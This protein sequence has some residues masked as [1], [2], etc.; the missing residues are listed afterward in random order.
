MADAGRLIFGSP[1][2][3]AYMEPSKQ[4][5]EAIVHFI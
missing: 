5:L 4:G 3:P 2:H 1:D